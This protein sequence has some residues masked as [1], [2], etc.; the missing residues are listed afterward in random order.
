MSCSCTALELFLSLS[1]TSLVVVQAMI[2]VNITSDTLACNAD[3]ALCF[4]AISSLCSF[5]C[6]AMG[7]ALKEEGSF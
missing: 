1:Q 5:I 7:F 3:R 2:M 4:F 6:A